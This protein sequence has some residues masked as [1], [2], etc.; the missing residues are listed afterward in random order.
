MMVIIVRSGTTGDLTMR[1]Y[2]RCLPA[3]AG[4]GIKAM[5]LIYDAIKK[6]V[7][8]RFRYECK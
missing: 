8:G 4:N 5:F 1:P 3:A 2:G 6:P 7:S